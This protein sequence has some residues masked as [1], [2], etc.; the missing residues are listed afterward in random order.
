M[1]TSYS[2]FGRYLL[3][4]LAFQFATLTP[5]DASSKPSVALPVVEP[6]HSYQQQ[7]ELLGIRRAPASLGVQITHPRTPKIISN[8]V[9]EITRS[10][11]PVQYKHHAVKITKAII[12]TARKYE[13]DPL[14]LVALIRHESQFRLDAVG[15]VGELGLM[16]IRPTTAEWLNEKLKLKK[17]DLR[18]PATNIEVG[19]YFLSTLREK[20]DRDSKLYMAAYNMGVTRLQQLLKENKSPVEYAGKVMKYYREYTHQLDQ[21]FTSNDDESVARKFK[22]ASNR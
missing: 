11:L 8:L 10:E 2:I 1:N 7:R 3:I 17:L 21:R 19:A 18:D 5:W 15:T 14:F 16:Q 9:L 22:V 12:R 4:I 20:Y 6:L 13:M